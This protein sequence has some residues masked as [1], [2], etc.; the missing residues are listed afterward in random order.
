MVASGQKQLRPLA[1]GDQGLVMASSEGA[2]RLLS[3]R[4]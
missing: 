2:G 3:H 1:A 4:R